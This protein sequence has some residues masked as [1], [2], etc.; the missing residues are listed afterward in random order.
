MVRTLDDLLLMP[1]DRR[2]QPYLARSSTLNTAQAPWFAGPGRT[3]TAAT[4]TPDRPVLAIVEYTGLQDFAHNR[5]VRECLGLP[6]HPFRQFS[7]CYVGRNGGPLHMGTTI[8]N[9]SAEVAHAMSV[10]NLRFGICNRL[11]LA[12]GTL[13]YVIMILTRTLSKSPKIPQLSGC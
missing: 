10:G 2:Y 4:P 13:N 7:K 3:N 5:E 6:S 12:L 8:Y 1:Q 9:Y 11:W